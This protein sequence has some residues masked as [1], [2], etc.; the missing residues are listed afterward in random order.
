MLTYII[1]HKI[2]GLQIKKG[3]KGKFKNIENFIF[4]LVPLILGGVQIIAHNQY[5]AISETNKT[6]T[7]LF[8]KKFEEAYVRFH[9][10]FQKQMKYE[11][12]EKVLYAVMFEESEG[13]NKIAFDY[14]LPVPGQ[15]A[16]Q[17][18]YKIDQNSGE[19]H[20]LKVV[21]LGD[22]EEGYKIVFMDFIYDKDESSYDI[23]IFG[24]ERMEIDG[25]IIIKPDT[26]II[27]PD[28]LRETLESKREEKQK[29]EVDFNNDKQKTDSEE[30]YNLFKIVFGIVILISVVLGLLLW[31]ILKRRKKGGIGSDLL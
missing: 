31:Y 30:L 16:I 7:L 21:L 18:F 4:L 29:I 13:I 5:M 23:K 8:D 10:E 3:F 20:E 28:S 19:K 9:P 14:Y 26:T 12:F 11:L 15:K 6:L 2:L 17:L 22:V 27:T 1:K 24:V 25:E